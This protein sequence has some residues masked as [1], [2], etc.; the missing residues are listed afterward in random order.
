MQALPIQPSMTPPPSTLAA[1]SAVL[2][3]FAGA[4]GSGGPERQLARLD[5]LGG[6]SPAETARV[7]ALNRRVV[8]SGRATAVLLVIS[9]AAMAAARFL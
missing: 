5:A 2:S 3:F 6:L 1:A 9:G 4:I 7:Q 8:F